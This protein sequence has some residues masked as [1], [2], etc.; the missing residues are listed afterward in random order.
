[1]YTDVL[2]KIHNFFHLDFFIYNSFIIIFLSFF[3]YFFS[4]LY[5][6]FNIHHFGFN[7]VY[8]MSIFF[9]FFFFFSQ[10]FFINDILFKNQIYILDISLIDNFFGTID[11]SFYLKIDLLSF[12]FLFLTTSIGLAAVIYSLTYFKNEPFSDRFILMLN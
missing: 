12:S 8:I 3:M 1:M 2:N 5:M 6:S 9:F 11:F 10:I 4:T 7:G